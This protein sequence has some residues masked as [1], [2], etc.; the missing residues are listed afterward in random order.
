MSAGRRWLRRLL[1]G[2]AAAV[3]LVVLLVLVVGPGRLRNGAER[4]VIG[5]FV[6]DKVRLD[7]DRTPL[8]EAARRV[9]GLVGARILID[10]GLDGLVTIHQDVPRVMAVPALTRVVNLMPNRC[11]IFGPAAQFSKIDHRLWDRETVPPATG[12]TLG[13]LA[14]SL[15]AQTRLRLRCL[16]EVAG[17]KVADPGGSRGLA[18][19]CDGLARQAGCAWTMGW[20]VTRIDPQ[21]AVQRFEAFNNLP[22]E[23]RQ[24]LFDRGLDRALRFYGELDPDLRRQAVDAMLSRIE[25]FAGAL[26]QAGPETR[27]RAAGAVTPLIQRGIGRLAYAD[28]PT[29]AELMPVVRAVCKLR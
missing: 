27:A 13:A 2:L 16:P 10:P 7:F 5:H 21:R 25:A 29:Q 28:A 19:L 3:G 14:A 6:N 8:A 11:A 18:A 1:L 26:D 23:R 22:E 12:G 17:A 9:E 15:E 20:V 4:A 24:K